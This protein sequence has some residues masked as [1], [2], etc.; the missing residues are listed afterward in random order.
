MRRAL[1]A[2]VVALLASTVALTAQSGDFLTLRFERYLDALRSQ[3]GIPGLS[4]IILRE[5]TVIWEAGLGVHNVDRSLPATP[6]TPYYIGDLTQVF[7]ATMVLQCVEQGTLSFDDPVVVSQAEGQAPVVATVRQLLIHA[8][9]AADGPPFQYSPTRFAALTSAVAQCSKTTYR[10][11]LVTSLLDRLGM[12]RTLPGLDAGSAA[13]VVFEP[14]R[15]ASYAGLIAE[16]ATPYVV[17]DKGR[18]TQSVLPAD[19]LNAAV[20]IVSSVRDL[21]RL[22]AALDQFV[23]LQQETLANAWAP[24]APV[25]GR[26]RPF[27]HGWFT[28]L[29]QGEPIVW[30]FGY[31]P[32]AGSALWLKLPARSTTLILLANSDGLSAQFSL[33][34]GNVT[35]SPFARIF[36]QLFR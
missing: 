4:G 9:T 27:G 2:L 33:P 12:A 11:R 8:G 34:D 3:A 20:G 29:D 16:V 24:R 14:E 19:G 6:D 26:P 5:G 28:Q 21:A 17:D 23:L 25:D 10:E 32:G 36:L 30:H 13:N 22:D 7:T 15:L 31:A 35:T 1:P 18:A